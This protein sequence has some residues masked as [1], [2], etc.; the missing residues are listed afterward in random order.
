MSA[1]WQP[2]HIFKAQ[3]G[4]KL[5]SQVLQLM[6]CGCCECILKTSFHSWWLFSGCKHSQGSEFKMLKTLFTEH[7]NLLC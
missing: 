1:F 2:H 5:T 7:L 6:S 3:P 4:V